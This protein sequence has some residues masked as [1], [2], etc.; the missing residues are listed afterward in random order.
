MG[1]EVKF[2][3]NVNEVDGTY[4]LTLY[5]DDGDDT[6]DTVPCFRSCFAGEPGRDPDTIAEAFSS[7]HQQA[8]TEVGLDG[9]LTQEVYDTLLKL[10]IERAG[11]KMP[12]YGFTPIAFDSVADEVLF[13][14]FSDELL[15]EE[16]KDPKLL[17]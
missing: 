17:N 13:M 6:L 14:L 2:C 16:E 5:C 1:T 10:S 11:E 3:I 12:P 8:M 15:D 4:G 9:V 7:C